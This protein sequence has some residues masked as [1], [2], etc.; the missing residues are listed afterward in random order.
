MKVTPE[1][2][3]KI[4]VGVILKNIWSWYL[5]IY[6]YWFLDLSSECNPNDKHVTQ[7][8]FGIHS[9]TKKN[10]ESFLERMKTFSLSTC[11]IRKSFTSIKDPKH[12][13][14]ISEWCPSLLINFDEERLMSMYPEPTSFEDYLPPGWTG[15]YENF[16]SLVP[17]NERYW[18]IK[19]KDMFKPF[20]T[21]HSTEL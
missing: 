7:F 21:S 11:D 18:I 3:S 4:F 15:S 6:D 10:A 17:I 1:Y 14:D 8:R 13:D 19:E 2:G 9:V 5:S 20:F 16:L 12:W